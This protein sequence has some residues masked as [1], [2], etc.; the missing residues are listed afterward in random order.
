[1]IWATR[2]RFISP[3]ERS[4]WEPIPKYV[5]CENGETGSC[6]YKF[7]AFDPIRRASSPVRNLPTAITKSS[8]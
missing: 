3:S 4:F 7:A 8:H 1:M 2:L 6:Q 5:H